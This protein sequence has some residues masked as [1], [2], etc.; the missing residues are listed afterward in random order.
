MLP[1]F[2]A[3][4]NSLNYKE[5]EDAFNFDNIPQTRL[6]MAYH[7]EVGAIDSGPANQLAHQFSMPVVV[8]VFIKGGRDTKASRDDALS[9]SETIL[10]EILKPSNR[11]GIAIKDV[12]PDG[13]T[14]N[15]LDTSDDND[16]ILEMNFTSIIWCNFT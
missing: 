3:R 12:Q 14:L 10:A 8:R 16:I 13:L 11:L 7:L 1:Y 4:L 9:Q 15:V 5:W 2:R 6:D